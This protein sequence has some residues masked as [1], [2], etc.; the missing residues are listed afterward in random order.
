M[1]HQAQ[2]SP[3][4]TKVVC[5]IE[6]AKN[7]QIPQIQFLKNPYVAISV[8]C[9]VG[10]TFTIKHLTNDCDENKPYCI[11]QY[12]IVFYCLAQ[13]FPKELVT[14]GKTQR[15]NNYD[16]AIIIYKVVLNYLKCFYYHWQLIKSSNIQKY[17]NSLKHTYL[18]SRYSFLK[19]K[20]EIRI[21]IES[22][23]LQVYLI[24]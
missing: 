6:D 14:L 1:L 12:C 4:I 16:N 9:L 22:C 23:Y 21:K 10:A 18:Q 3:V 7:I 20:S 13:P 15:I 2:F 24:M 11:L 8:H 19:V 17:L 5:Y